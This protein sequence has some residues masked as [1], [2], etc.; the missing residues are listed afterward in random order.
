MEN[1]E[2]KRVRIDVRFTK[3]HPYI[4]DFYYY[5]VNWCDSYTKATGFND[6]T[7]LKDYNSYHIIFQR[8]CDEVKSLIIL[9]NNYHL[10]DFRKLQIL[11][12][13]YF[14]RY[15]PKFEKPR[16]FDKDYNSKQK[17]GLNKD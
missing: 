3:R 13:K 10:K 2:N 4:W 1:L 6:L 8:E 9:C 15:S 11:I 16:D 5:L 14:K 7:I 17:G 12:R